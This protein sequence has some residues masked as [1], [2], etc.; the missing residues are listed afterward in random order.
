V[1]SL[2]GG[3]AATLTPE[4]TDLV[5]YVWSPTVPASPGTASIPAT[6][7]VWSAAAVAWLA[8]PVNLAL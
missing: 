6:D 8:D 4:G 3:Y 5:E 1:V 2:D 7:T